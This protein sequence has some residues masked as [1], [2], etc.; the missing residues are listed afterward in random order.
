MNKENMN[1]LIIILCLYCMLFN[2]DKKLCVL[3]I[4]RK[5]RLVL[6]MIYYCCVPN[7]GNILLFNE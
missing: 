4:V 3:S 2:E 7:D 5:V 6:I 1:N